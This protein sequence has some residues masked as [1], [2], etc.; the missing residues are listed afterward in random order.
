MTIANGELIMPLTWAGI[1]R[2]GDGNRNRM[3]SLEDRSSYSASELRQQ[4]P[5]WTVSDCP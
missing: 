2:A 5:R 4:R 3:T 1:T